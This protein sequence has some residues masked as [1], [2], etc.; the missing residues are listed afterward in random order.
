[1]AA[2]LLNLLSIATMPDFSD[3]LKPASPTGPEILRQEREQSDVPV[4]ELAH[5]LLSRNDF[6]KRQERIIPILEKEPLFNK[7]K[8]Q[9]LSRPDR[10]QL[11]LAR[12]KQLR[13]LAD[14]HSW[15][16]EDYS[17]STYLCDDVSPFMVHDTMFIQTVKEQGSEEQRAYWIPKIQK[18]EAIGC[19]AQ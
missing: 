12:G 11:G 16:Q 9:H 6:L 1:L 13:R 7:A 4:D 18:W 14:K 3:D 2:D 15:D 8:Q 10:Y 5:H 17:M 19:Y